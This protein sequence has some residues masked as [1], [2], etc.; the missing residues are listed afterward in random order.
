MEDNAP[1]NPG[2]PDDQLA[3]EIPTLPVSDAPTAPAPAEPTDQISLN[4]A[5]HIDQ[6]VPG[7]VLL[8]QIGRGGFGTVY[9]GLQQ[10]VNREVA[11]KLDQRDLASES[12]RHRFLREVTATGQVSAHPNIVTLYDGGT[13]ESNHPYM[14]M[15]LCPGGSLNDRL[16]STGPVPVGEVIDVG[17]AVAD[18]LDAAHQAGIL[19][20]D[21]KPANILITRYGTPAL[22]D[23]GLASLPSD[24]GVASMSQM[25]LT[26]SY[27][28]PEAF[29]REPATPLWDIYSLGA[30]LYAMLIGRPA[31]WTP[32]GPPSIEELVR[33]SREPLPPLNLAE[34]P[35]LSEVLAHATSPNP[36]TRTAS[37]GLLREHLTWARQ[38]LAD[39]HTVAHVPAFAAPVPDQTK[40][41]PQYEPSVHPEKAP[42]RRSRKPL[43]IA[44]VIAAFGLAA[45]SIAWGTMMAGGDDEPQSSQQQQ[46]SENVAQGGADASNAAGSDSKAT[47]TLEPP[48]VGTCWG[49]RVVISGILNGARPCACTEEHYT[50]G[51]ASGFLSEGSTEYEDDQ[52][53]DPVVKATCTREALA[54][55]LDMSSAPDNVTIDVLGPTGTKY[56]QGDR[57]F[58]CT[59][60]VD[61]MGLVDQ[62]LKELIAGS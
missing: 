18:A 35:G 5:A 47:P 53:A 62:P 17:I 11:V 15:E 23:F 25:A 49:G 36:T 32:S 12:D 31:H 50:E 58:V 9:R 33:L 38:Q 24:W 19:H 52:V 44:A 40:A 51:F 29:R 7:I 3:A 56:A 16:R 13:T 26:P 34:A 14:V 20:R 27:A 6:V 45:G 28:P 22:S 2:D 61:G 46:G 8:E 42:Q 1:D 41:I 39:P 54:T 57:G 48:E 21:V 37:A 4:A 30:S 60:S 55:Y 59:A 10:S 43:I